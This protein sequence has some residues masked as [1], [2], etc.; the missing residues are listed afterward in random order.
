MK[1]MELLSR[2]AL[3]FC[4]EGKKEEAACHAL[5]TLCKWLLADWKDVTPQLKQACYPLAPVEEQLCSTQLH[6][7]VTPYYWNTPE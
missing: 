2:A 1:A 5:L 7:A 4:Q 6:V 3:S